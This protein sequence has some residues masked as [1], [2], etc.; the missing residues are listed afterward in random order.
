MVHFVLRCIQCSANV[1]FSVSEKSEERGGVNC[2]GCKK[3]ELIIER[4]ETD[5][6]LVIR[7]ALADLDTRLAQIEDHL[8]ESTKGDDVRFIRGETH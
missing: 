4:Y 7:A 6:G 1:E 5:S 2:P 8:I 3:G